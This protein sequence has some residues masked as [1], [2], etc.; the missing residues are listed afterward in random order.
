MTANHAIGPPSLKVKSMRSGRTSNLDGSM[1]STLQPSAKAACSSFFVTRLGSCVPG[2]SSL[3][4]SRNS[5]L[6]GFRIASSLST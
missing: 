4:H 5:R 2:S 6:P 3:K 1:D